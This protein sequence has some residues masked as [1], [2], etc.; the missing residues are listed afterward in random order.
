M[1]KSIIVRKNKKKLNNVNLFPTVRSFEIID[2]EIIRKRPKE[3]YK[4]NFKGQKKII[5]LFIFI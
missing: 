5:Y 1:N 2:I 3:G 4:I